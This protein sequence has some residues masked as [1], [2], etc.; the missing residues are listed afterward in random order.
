MSKTGKRENR[1]KQWDAEGGRKGQLGSE[2]ALVYA[3]LKLFKEL[4]HEIQT[5]LANP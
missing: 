3:E 5:L 1:Q 4:W 2:E